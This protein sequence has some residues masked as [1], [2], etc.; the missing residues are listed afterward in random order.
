MFGILGCHI[1]DIYFSNI[2][3]LNSGQWVLWALWSLLREHHTECMSGVGVWVC[4][5]LGCH[6]ISFPSQVLLLN[7]GQWALWSL[8][9]ESE[10]VSHI[11]YA[12]AGRV[13]FGCL[14]LWAATT[15]VSLFLEFFSILVN[16]CCGLCGHCLEF[17]TERIL[18]GGLA[19]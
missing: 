7:S 4:G 5:T 16:W 9:R 11:E 10:R 15:P 14:V 19:V 17:L 12:R 8:N 18:G 3:A 2:F 1:I 13:E 6:N